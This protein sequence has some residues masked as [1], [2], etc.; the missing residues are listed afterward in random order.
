MWIATTL[1]AFMAARAALEA[2]AS[3]TELAH[4]RPT[5]RFSAVVTQVRNELAIGANTDKRLTAGTALP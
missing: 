1:N 2:H 4:E 5:I 3:L